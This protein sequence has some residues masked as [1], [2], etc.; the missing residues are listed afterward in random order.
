MTIPEKYTIVDLPQ[1]LEQRLHPTITVWNRLEGRPR[2]SNFDRALKAE[3]RDA[4]WMLTKQWQIGEFRADDAGSP[5][6]AKVRMRT[7]PVTKYQAAGAT[8]EVYD[9]SVPMEARTE[10]LPIALQWNNQA[11]RLDLRAQLG[12]QWRK[13][14]DGAAL[15]AYTPQYLAR[16]P[17]QLPAQDTHGDYVYA[18]RQGWQQYAALAGRC[19]DGADLY[20]YLT[21]NP[22]QHA[23]DGITLSS[24][25]DQLALDNLGAQFVAWY[26]AQYL[27]ETGQSAWQPDYLEYQLACSATQAGQ[28]VVLAADEY[29]Q[30]HLDWYAFDRSTPAGGLGQV[31]PTPPTDEQVTVTPFIPTPVTFQGMPDPRWWALEDRKTDFGSV[32]PSTTDVAQLLLMEFGLIYAN[33]WFMLPCRLPV[34][35]LARIEGLAVT[36]VFGERFWI[37]A[38]GTGSQDNWHRWSMFQLSSAP[39]AQGMTDTSLLI[40]PSTATTFDGDPM[41]KVEFARDEVANMVWAIERTIPAVAGQGRSGKDEARETLLYQQQ[42]ITT[43]APPPAAYA[44]SIAYRAMSSVPEHWIPFAP[45][46]VDGSNRQIQLQ[47]SRMLRIIDGDPNPPVKV[48]PR[49]TLVRQGLDVSPPQPYFVHEE[50]VPRAGAIVTERFRR[51]RWNGGTTYVWLGVR[52]QTGRGEETSGLSFDSL[53]SVTP[54]NTGA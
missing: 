38:A 35:E 41:E 20:I 24:P 9:G 53:V 16:Y 6:S 42:L 30:G 45:V 47:R 22:A 10:Q 31:T 51:T 7:S 21:S 2:T 37:I 32:S 40:P 48:P 13:L 52:K 11:M 15:S 25:G 29:A 12:R 28:E 26:R 5:V 39:P 1:A 18:H 46:H 8:T 3:V 54:Q 49:T 44:A 33:D 36:N 14:L 23:S 34:G 50:E 17:F 27:Q 19:I 43:A 4:L